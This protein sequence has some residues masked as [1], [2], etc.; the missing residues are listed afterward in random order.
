MAATRITSPL[1]RGTRPFASWCKQSRGNTGKILDTHDEFR[2]ISRPKEGKRRHAT[3]SLSLSLT[4]TT[5]KHEEREIGLG[6]FAPC[7]DGSDDASPGS[8]SLTVAMGQEMVSMVTGG[9]QEWHG[10]VHRLHPRRSTLTF[11]QLTATL[12]PRAGT[13]RRN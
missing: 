3:N 8:R 13:L 7:R 2:R 6:S 12:D 9:V 5:R 11:A 1:G 4:S 10:I